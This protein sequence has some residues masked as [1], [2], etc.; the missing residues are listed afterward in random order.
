MRANSWSATLDLS[1][2]S[3]N[4]MSRFGGDSEQVLRR[5]LARLQ[6]AGVGVLGGERQHLGAQAGRAVGDAQ[7]DQ[8]GLAGVGEIGIH[9]DRGVDLLA[10]LVQGD[11]LVGRLDLREQR[12]AVLAV[13][14]DRLRS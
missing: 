14:L 12:Q 1:S 2:I 13:D 6:R 7:A 4:S 11:Q 8:V 3:S 5:L 9:L 10:G